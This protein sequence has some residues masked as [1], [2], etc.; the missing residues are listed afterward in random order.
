MKTIIG[1]TSKNEVRCGAWFSTGEE[2]VYQ[3]SCN[4]YE[5][6]RMAELVYGKDA[7]RK[8]RIRLNEVRKP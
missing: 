2:K 5:S 4:V 3:F 6:K 1:W 8:V 7:I